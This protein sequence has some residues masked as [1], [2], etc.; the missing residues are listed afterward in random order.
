MKKQT[1]Q[2]LLALSLFSVVLSL[3][4]CNRDNPASTAEYNKSYSALDAEKAAQASKNGASQRTGA[5]HRP[6]PAQRSGPDVDI[7]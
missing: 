4:A 1:F 2:L 5:S 6:G 3:C 7:K